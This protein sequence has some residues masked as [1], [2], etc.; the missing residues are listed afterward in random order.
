MFPQ[1]AAR[2]TLL[3]AYGA[4]VAND[5]PEDW[6]W[7]DYTD[8]DRHGWEP[9]IAVPVTEGR[10]EGGSQLETATCSWT[11]RNEDGEHT[12]DED[13]GRVEGTPVWWLLDLGHGQ[14]E[15]FAG[16]L[17]SL[18]PAWSG[19]TAHGATVAMSAH[20][21]LGRLQRGNPP[22]RGPVERAMTAA[23]PAWGWRLD[24]GQTAQQLASGLP[25]GRPMT[26]DQLPELAAVTDP[27]LAGAVGGYPLIIRDGAWVGSA[28]AAVTGLPADGWTWQ[29]WTMVEGPAG[30]PYA[31]HLVRIDCDGDLSRLRLVHEVNADG[32]QGITLYV[33]GDDPGVPYYG[34][35]GAT[36][37]DVTVPR[38]VHTQIRAYQVDADTVRLHCVVDGNDAQLDVGDALDPVTLGAPHTH[39][40][41]ATATAASGFD[42]PAGIV[43]ASV[44]HAA[45]WADPDAA[46]LQSAGT[47]H[48]GETA[49]DRIS[50]LCGEL[51]LPVVVEAGDSE[52][53]GPQ[54]A[55]TDGDVLLEAEA[56]DGGRLQ[57]EAF[58]FRYRPRL[59]L[60]NQAAALVIDASRGELTDPWQPRRD[61]SAVRNEWTV[62]RPSGSSATYRDEA[63]QRLRG[64]LTDGATINPADDARLVQH[65]AW[66]TARTTTAGMRVSALGID[67][68][69]VPRLIQSWQQLR[70][71]DRV[72]VVGLWSRLPQHPTDELELLH[73]GR[74]YTLGP[75]RRHL[76]G[77]LHCSPAQ[78]M[79][80]GILGDLAL[81]RLGAQSTLVEALPA[82]TTGAVQ[83]AYTGQRW[84]T[85]AG[86][87][88]MIVVIGGEHIRVSGITGTT[89]PQTMTIVA[90]AVNGSR[91]RRD[92]PAGAPVQVLDAFRL[93]L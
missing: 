10:S 7:V 38:W 93:A 70:L 44:S 65:A 41:G 73:E 36:L 74:S 11:M 77:Q 6:P 1:D 90:R 68:A 37:P 40:I 32:T 42:T 47:G 76:V 33:H 87:F 57:E 53:M 45:L 8:H 18:V 14:V 78:P 66:R 54:Q 84:T 50:R 12:P 3:I 5:P 52:P 58:G 46:S 27:V 89:S 15:M 67:L 4:D 24:D 86:H 63:H 62:S 75:G 28:S 59:A 26:G 69:D 81:G 34:G 21:V 85:T 56:T 20:G 91:Y 9:A 72:Q 16:F 30:G 43:R 71:G 80:V 64:R 22:A 39:T 2:V 17:S 35:F 29:G 51:G 79:T 83:V 19:R 48:A 13:L 92:H 31:A 88:P 82:G 60:Y 55:A 25:G 49:A 61:L 23:P